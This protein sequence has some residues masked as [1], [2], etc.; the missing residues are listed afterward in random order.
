M[1]FGASAKPVFVDINPQTF[2]LDPAAFEAA[3]T[4]ATKGVIPVHLFGQ[5]A[6]MKPIVEIAGAHKL[7]VIEDA[8][9][10]IGASYGDQPTGSLGDVGCISFYPTKNLGGFGDGGMLVTSNDE[11]A[12][13][14]R[15]LRTH[16]M[17]PRYFHK[18]VGIN[19]RL[20]SIQ[21]AVLNI[22]LPQLEQWTSARHAMRHRTTSCSRHND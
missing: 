8:A 4:P 19:S 17:K 3:I 1:L 13:R 21:A 7:M 10:A 5:P 20:D 2:N 12:D 15:L 16:G 11:L 18:E 14:L 6:D 22:K 9:Q